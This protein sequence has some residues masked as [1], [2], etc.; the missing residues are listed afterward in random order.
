MNRAGALLLFLIALLTGGPAAAQQHHMDVR[1]VP[2]T[3]SQV[4][5]A[6][7]TV[8]L[9]MH[10]QPGWH[11]YWRN[12]G[13]AGAEPRIAW[14]LPEGWSAEPLQYPVP[15]RLIVAG[16]MNYVFARDYA[17]LATL[18]VPAGAELGAT[19]PIDARLDYLVCTDQVCVPETATVSTNLVVAAPRRAQPR[20]PGARARRCRARSA[21]T[22]ISRRRAAASG[23]PSR[24]PPRRAV[25]DPYFFPATQDA[26]AYSAAQSFSR[27]G[28]TL[29]VE[30][31]GGAARGG[32]SR[33]RG[34]A[35]ARRRYRARAHRAA[36]PG[37]AGGRAGRGDRRRERRRGRRARPALGLSRRAAR[38]AD[39]QRHALRLPD[40]QPQGA[41]PRPRRRDRGRRA[42]G[43]A[44]LCGGRDR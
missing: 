19:F 28:D 40:P 23:S 25:T 24:S 38:R 26:I 22:R 20:L 17:L 39:P 4:A 18:H 5:G 14:H 7:V 42:A 29:I 33:D 34:R 6:T 44:R 35:P 31:G 11:G 12:P 27:S 10:P 8:A 3:A 16:L 30:T 13:D 15:G 2:E 41:E 43:G 32:A 36:G 37:A 1:L 21:P 9:V